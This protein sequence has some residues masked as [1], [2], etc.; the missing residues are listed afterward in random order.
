MAPEH[1]RVCLV[2]QSMA[3]SAMGHVQGDSVQDVG[4]DEA[5]PSAIVVAHAALTSGAD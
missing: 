5:L 2:P 4:H 1:G 3:A